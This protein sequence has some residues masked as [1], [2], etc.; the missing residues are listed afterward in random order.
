MLGWPVLH[1]CVVPA[2]VCLHFASF[3]DICI[4]WQRGILYLAAVD[5]DL[6]QSLHS[7]SCVD[8]VA[9]GKDARR[10]ALVSRGAQLSRLPAT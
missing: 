1:W 2:F 10:T 7:S 3:T 4:Q 6:I 9:V 5:S 8:A